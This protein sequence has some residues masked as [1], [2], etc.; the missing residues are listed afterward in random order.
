MSN[1]PLHCICGYQPKIDR[2]ESELELYKQMAIGALEKVAE[3]T[4]PIYKE[5]PE[6]AEVPDMME[7]D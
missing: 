1:L 7:E 2:L 6:I 3:L 4:N 5:E